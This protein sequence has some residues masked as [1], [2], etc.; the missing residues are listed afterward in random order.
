MSSTPDDMVNAMIANL[1]EKTGKSLDDW[2]AVVAAS[3]LGK[4]GEIV[5]HLK[6]E[7]GMT[8]GYANLVSQLYRQREDGPPPAETDLVDAQYQGKEGL[9]P[10]YDALVARVSAFGDD[11]DVSPRK[12]YVT[13]RRGKQFGIL[14][15]ST[16]TRMDVGIQLKGDPAAGRLEEGKRFGGMVS[17]QVA[18]SALDDIDDELVGW[19]E[20]AY[21]RA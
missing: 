1:P 17:H 13:L 14:K 3:G 21:R 8:H 9:R 20:E 5:A 10:L 15:P 19:L 12:T 16:K 18:V 7:H 11:V 4:H 2:F 6:S